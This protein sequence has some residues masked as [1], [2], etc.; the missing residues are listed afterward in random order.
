M[1]RLHHSLVW[2]AFGIYMHLQGESLIAKLTWAQLVTMV[3][4]DFHLR[5]HM[6]PR[7]VNP[8]L[9]K[10]PS[11]TSCKLGFLFGIHW[12]TGSH[13]GVWTGM[14]THFIQCGWCWLFDIS[15][16]LEQSH[17][18]YLSL[19]QAT[20]SAW[21]V[22]WAWC[23]NRHAYRLW[24]LTSNCSSWSQQWPPDDRGSKNW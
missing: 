5:I 22:F 19:T 6:M 3:F 9:K 23:R 20:I 18:S 8:C 1:Q 7:V 21:I 16:V 10:D 13:A 11:Q 17:S 2:S 14:K 15:S 24:G 4:R 12:E